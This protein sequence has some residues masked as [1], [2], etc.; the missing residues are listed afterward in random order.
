MNFSVQE[1]HRAL[2]GEITRG[3]NGPQVLCPGPGHTGNDR[4]LAVSPAADGNDFI[5][6]SHA[7]DDAIVCKDY[8]RRKLGLPPFKPGNGK[9]HA[10]QPQQKIIAK[11]YDYCDEGGSLLFQVVRYAPKDFRQRRPDG[12]DGW[13]W[14]LEGVRRVPYQLPELLEALGSEKPVFICEGEKDVD[15]L[16]L[17]GIPAT[18]NPQG[19]GKWR[20]EYSEHFRGATV[21]VL[22]DNDAP[23]RE[24]AEQVALSLKSVGATVHETKGALNQERVWRIMVDVTRLVCGEATDG[25]GWSCV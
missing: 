11:A 7:G 15:A 17:L 10:S 4:S 24:H 25:F 3:N 16:R 20:D 23:G 13:I 5:V 19:A 12:K 8:V 22:P 9:D 2:G 18:C 6:F 14:N 21:C 1:L